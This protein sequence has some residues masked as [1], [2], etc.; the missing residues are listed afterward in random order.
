MSKIIVGLYGSVVDIEGNHL[1][2]AGAGKD[3]LAQ[4]MK[5]HDGQWETYALAQPIKE[6]INQFMK[7]DE[8]H[9]EGNLKEVELKVPLDVDW[10]VDMA[11]LLDSRFGD[12]VDAKCEGFKREE[13]LA[14]FCTVFGL[15]LGDRF[16]TISPRKAYQLF[17]TE[18]GRYM[19]D[20][21]WLDLIPT[22]K[23]YLIITDFRFP[24][25]CTWAEDNEVEMVKVLSKNTSRITANTGHSSEQAVELRNPVIVENFGNLEELEQVSQHLS[26]YF[27]MTL[28]GD[29]GSGFSLDD[30]DNF[31]AEDSEEDYQGVE[32]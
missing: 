22:E 2:C 21:I 5:D 29:E 9:S 30:L 25:E 12:Y 13:L 28:R 3:T 32:L 24:N 20:N 6:V 7:W 16:I 27:F 4:F 18:F 31:Q 11:H 26:D 8:Q 17:G 1:G 15:K 14:H 23:P 10:F 19:N